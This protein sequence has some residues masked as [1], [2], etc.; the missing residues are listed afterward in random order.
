MP[1]HVALFAGHTGKLT[2]IRILRPTLG[3]LEK[4]N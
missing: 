4:V 1:N 3:L 2:A